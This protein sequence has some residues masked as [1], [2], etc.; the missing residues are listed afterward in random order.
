MP[1]TILAWKAVRD[2]LIDDESRLARMLSETSA[3]LAVVRKKIDNLAEAPAPDKVKG[4]C[5]PV[6]AKPVPVGDRPA[7]L[8]DLPS[9]PPFGYIKG[10][11]AYIDGNAAGDRFVIWTRHPNEWSEPTDWIYLN[12]AGDWTEGPYWVAPTKQAAVNFINKY[13]DKELAEDPA[14]PLICC[15]HGKP[16]YVGFGPSA[17]RKAAVKA[18]ANSYYIW[19]PWPGASAT[20]D[21]KYLD[22]DGNW[23]PDCLK[24]FPHMVSAVAFAQE[25]NKRNRA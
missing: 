6:A 13:A 1:A 22:G 2:E 7:N 19:T 20:D 8:N 14:E 11:P 16:A 10:K 15:I 18:T 25:V 3:A 5:N 17:T 24:W 4:R 21:H 9:S 23:R 12:A